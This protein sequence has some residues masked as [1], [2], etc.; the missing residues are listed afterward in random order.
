MRTQKIKKETTTTLSKLPKQTTKKCT[1]K[2]SEP[3]KPK[4]PEGIHRLKVY[5]KWTY[6]GAKHEPVILLKGEWLRNA[7]FEKGSEILVTVNKKQLII[8]F[9]S[10]KT[11]IS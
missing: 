8:N 2:A 3:P 5:G 4:L 9:E 1:C 10:D 6:E 11:S 7:G